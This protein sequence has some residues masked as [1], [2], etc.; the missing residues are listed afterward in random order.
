LPILLHNIILE[1]LLLQQY[2]VC[3]NKTRAAIILREEVKVTKSS[4]VHSSGRHEQWQGYTSGQILKTTNLTIS[5]A[6]YDSGAA[7]GFHFK[8]S[9]T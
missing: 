9:Y 7:K 3:A 8:N 1:E 4:P 5:L 2:Q 6:V